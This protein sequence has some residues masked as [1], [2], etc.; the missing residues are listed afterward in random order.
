[1]EAAKQVLDLSKKL[2]NSIVGQASE[3][4][5][6]HMKVKLEQ[7]YS[8]ASTSEAGGST[9]GNFAQTS[10]SE[11]IS[12]ESPAHTSSP[13]DDQTLSSIFTKLPKAKNP[14]PT[15]APK[16]KPANVSKSNEVQTTICVT[17]SDSA[18]W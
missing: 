1:M 15:T 6:T 17:A 14:T 12:L 5:K 18:S 13:I 9:A 8:E 4:L 11:P 16:P 10:I 3:V 7:G 2:E